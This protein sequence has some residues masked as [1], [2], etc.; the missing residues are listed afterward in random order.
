MKVEARIHFRGNC[1]PITLVSEEGEDLRALLAEIHDR[2]SSG[3]P[4]SLK[5]GRRVEVF[6][7]GEITRI[8]VFGIGVGADEVADGLGVDPAYRGFGAPG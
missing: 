7:P 1:A 3:S 2:R 4:M 5:A 6:Y 8:R